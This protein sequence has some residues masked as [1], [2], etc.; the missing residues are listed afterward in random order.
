MVQLVY[1]KGW[2]V[3]LVSVGRGRMLRLEGIDDLQA[4]LA[5][6]RGLGL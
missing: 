2:P 6:V 1:L 3:D 4:R 5:I